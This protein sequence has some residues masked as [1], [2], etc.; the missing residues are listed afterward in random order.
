M[1]NKFLI[2]ILS[3]FLVC[4]QYSFA[5]SNPNF[6]VFDG[7]MIKDKPD[8]FSK[9]FSRINVIYEDDLTQY[10]NRYPRD[11][12][13]RKINQTRFNNSARLVS[14]NNYPV[15][16]DVESWPLYERNLNSNIKKYLNLLNEFKNRSQR[17]NVGFFGVLP[18][19]NVYKYDSRFDEIANESAIAFPVFYTKNEN[20]TAWLKD[21]EKQI[22]IIKKQWPH[23]KIYGF[24]WPQYHSHNPNL[25]GKYIS[26]DFWKFQLQE[27]YKRCDGVVV[28][29]PPFNL[30]NREKISWNSNA[31]WYK[32]TINFIREKEII[33]K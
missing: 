26:N 30:A 13:Y 27:L 18:Y 20:R 4:E 10:D 3:L 31:L 28:W 11:K 2:W 23:L 21:V 6:L 17:T 5:Q 29:M 14:S 15:C 7:I 32:S 9:S 19:G 33:R 8:L 16:L 25:K 1:N 24:I 22:S 12:N